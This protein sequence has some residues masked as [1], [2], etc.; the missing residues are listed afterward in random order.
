MQGKF[1][2]GMGIQVATI[3]AAIGAYQNHCKAAITVIGTIDAPYN[4]IR[5]IHL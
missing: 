1:Q 2:L 3:I 5:K 4:L